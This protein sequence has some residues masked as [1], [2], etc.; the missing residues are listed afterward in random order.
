MEKTN[1]LVLGLLKTGS[2]ALIDLLKEYECF[3]LIPDEFNDYRAPGLVADQLTFTPDDIFPNKIEKI[4]HF[5]QKLRL[6]YNL[7]PIFE[8]KKIKNSSFKDRF[9]FSKKRIKELNSLK[10]LNKK[11]ISKDELEDKIHHTRLWIKNLGVIHA[12]N[13]PYILFNQPLET[14]NDIDIWKKVFFPFK[15]IV[16]LRD[17]KDQLADI[18]NF[19]YLYE[20]FGDPFM[21]LSGVTLETIYGR[22]RAGA[23]NFHIDAIKRRLEW[24]DSLKNHLE[25]DSLLLIDFKDLTVNY[26]ETLNA[27]EE[28]IKGMKNKHNKKKLFFD[29]KTGQKS[30]GIYNEFLNKKELKSIIELEELYEKLVGANSE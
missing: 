16:V 9:Y 3:G 18:I 14:V 20:T 8:L 15:L 25:P 5:K 12:K 23:L 2:S 10:S 22:N 28:F 7:F 4:T 6:I 26:D 29:P 1:I 13:K 30:I 19:G 17:P 21:T 11:L 24:V 27:I